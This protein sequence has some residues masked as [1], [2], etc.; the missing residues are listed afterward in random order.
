[1]YRLVALH[2]QAMTTAAPACKHRERIESPHGTETVK[3]VC[4]IC[5]AEREYPAAFKYGYNN[6]PLNEPRT[7]V[8]GRKL[9]RDWTEPLE[10]KEPDW[11][12]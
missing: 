8:L 10:W 9:K 7:T 3:G 11:R 1:M 4:K 2:G 6:E 12:G 5:G